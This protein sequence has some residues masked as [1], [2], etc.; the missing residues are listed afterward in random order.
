MPARLTMPER[1]FE[2]GELVEYESRTMGRWIPAQVVTGDPPSTSLRGTPLP[3]C[4]LPPRVNLDVQPQASRRRI[5]PRMPAGNMPPGLQLGSGV[6]Q[7]DS[8]PAA[9][10]HDDSTK[11]TAQVQTVEC[12]TT[13]RGV[14][15]EDHAAACGACLGGIWSAVLGKIA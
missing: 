7:P 6:E 9:Y 4:Q 12:P 8:E 10:D 2:S 11:C 13:D 15:T 1:R 3:R 14:Q 5:R